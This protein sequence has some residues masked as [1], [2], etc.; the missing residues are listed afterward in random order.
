M[1]HKNDV[2]KMVWKKLH[3]KSVI[4]FSFTF[5]VLL[6]FMFGKDLIYVYF[7]I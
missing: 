4:M 7:I 1:L 3:L 2:E 6:F 5:T